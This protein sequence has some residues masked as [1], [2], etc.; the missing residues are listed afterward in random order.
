MLSIVIG[1]LAIFQCY[2][3]HTAG[4]TRWY[5]SKWLGL[6]M[7]RG[8]SLGR[9]SIWETEHSLLWWV[10]NVLSTLTMGWLTPS[11]GSAAVRRFNLKIMSTASRTVLLF[12]HTGGLLFLV[13]YLFAVFGSLFGNVVGRVSV[14]YDDH[15][16]DAELTNFND[17]S[18]SLVA[19]FQILMSNNWQVPPIITPIVPP[20]V[21][22]SPP[23]SP[24][25]LPVSPNNY[26]HGTPS[27]RCSAP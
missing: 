6:V 17:I 15:P 10:Q 3:G 9:C 7:L 12:V 26:T 19:L 14:S 23:A 11:W 1:V 13:L 21:L 22:S 27:R 25:T 2:Y 5:D 24:P 18:H 16:V 4:C 8:L 20:Q